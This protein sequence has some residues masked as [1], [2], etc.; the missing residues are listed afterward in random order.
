M[1]QVLTSILVFFAISVQLLSQKQTGSF[2]IVTNTC[3][4]IL[5]LVN[6]NKVIYF[7]LSD[8]PNAI[9]LYRSLSYG[10]TGRLYFSHFHKRCILWPE[11][12]PKIGL[13]RKNR[14]FSTNIKS[15]DE[16]IGTFRHTCGFVQVGPL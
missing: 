1:T 7:Q 3:N 8:L 12:K 14:F 4:H 15:F 10:L 11:K 9:T 16:E 2:T 5:S 6:G 13:K